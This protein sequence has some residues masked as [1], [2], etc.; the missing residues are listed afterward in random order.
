MWVWDATTPDAPPRR[1]TE[2]KGY[3]RFGSF[4]AGAGDAREVYYLSDAHG[5]MAEVWSYDLASGAR[6]RVFAAP[7]DVE[8]VSF[9]SRGRY[10]VTST[11]IDGHSV[12]QLVDTR[13]G[14]EVT[15]AGL[16]RGE[17]LE[18]SF[19][20]G[21]D[22]LALYVSSD[23]APRELHVWDLAR[24]SH[25]RLTRSLGAAIDPRHLVDG[26]V[27]RF[28]SFDGLEIPAILYRPHG[29][30]PERRAPAMVWVHGGPGGQL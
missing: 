4:T 20:P 16:P 19:A 12:L 1:V 13:S 11:N 9:S 22:R 24:G 8:L 30:G 26:E 27:V 21:E 15:L 28:A 10:R 7:G 29:A 5:E 3:E 14:A 17:V 25:R 6:R 2:A 23:R 18:V